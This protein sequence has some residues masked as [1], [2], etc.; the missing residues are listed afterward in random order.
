M[1]YEFRIMGR[2]DVETISQLRPLEPVEASPSQVF[3]AT[4]ANPAELRDLI[5]RVH[6]LGLLLV[7][8]KRLRLTPQSVA[9]DPQASSRSGSAH[10]PS[11]SGAVGL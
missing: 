4:A 1:Q 2:L 7:D 3:L 6:A 5:A 10:V 8:V 9:A 11:N